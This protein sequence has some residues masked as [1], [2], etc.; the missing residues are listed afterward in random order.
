MDKISILETIVAEKQAKKVS[1]NDGAKNRKLLIDLTS[2][3][4]ALK[5]I[6]AVNDRNREKLLNMQWPHM[7]NTIW[8]VTAKAA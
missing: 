5:V 7:L 4:V 1:W 2:A 6:N 8:S 3:S